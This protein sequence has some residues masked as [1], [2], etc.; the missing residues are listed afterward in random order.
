MKAARLSLLAFGPLRLLASVCNSLALRPVQAR[1][2]AGRVAGDDRSWERVSGKPRAPAPQLAA[3]RRRAYGA[4][5][6]THFKFRGSR[7]ARWN[8]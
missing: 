6:E 7:Q 5:A 4:K 3:R 2:R 1:R 8:H